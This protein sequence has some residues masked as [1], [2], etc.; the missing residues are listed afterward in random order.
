M[1][2]IIRCCHFVIRMSFLEND[3]DGFFDL[4]AFVS[5]LVR[6]SGRLIVGNG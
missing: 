4:C 2:M 5:S 1:T 3:K 6:H